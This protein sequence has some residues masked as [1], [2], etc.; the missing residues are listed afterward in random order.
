METLNEELGECAE[1]AVDSARTLGKRR[2]RE[3]ERE[4]E[5]RK[6]RSEGK[7][8]KDGKGG[9]SGVISWLDVI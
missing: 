1:Q 7:E 6:G 8:E 2:V 5:G 9:A 3:N 4:R